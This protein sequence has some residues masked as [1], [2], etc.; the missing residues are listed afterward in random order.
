MRVRRSSEASL[1]GKETL[2]EILELE[3][4]FGVLV[5]SSVS[6]RGLA[7]QAPAA[8]RCAGLPPTER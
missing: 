8:G 6:P 3:S 5:A 2:K 4:T 1:L 7:A